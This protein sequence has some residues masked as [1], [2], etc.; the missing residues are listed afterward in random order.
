MVSSPVLFPRCILLATRPGLW[1]RYL[2][3]PCWDPYHLPQPERNTKS[4]WDI[5]WTEW[6]FLCTSQGLVRQSTLSFYHE[7]TET[8]HLWCVT[9]KAHSDKGIK[10]FF[11]RYNNF[12]DT[13][14]YSLQFLPFLNLF[15]AL[16]Q[17][18]YKPGSRL[19][20]ILKSE[21]FIPFNRTHMYYYCNEEVVSSWW[22]IYLMTTSSISVTEVQ[23]LDFKS[24]ENS[25][26]PKWNSVCLL[27][28]LQKR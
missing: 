27:Q 11:E 8:R 19:T 15:C 7:V 10:C 5:I 26:R 12:M 6:I 3:S 21:F 20:C 14:D 24:K 18:T 23:I 13:P 22:W 2:W 17:D 9:T 4:M 25:V 16:Q 28:R 1:Q